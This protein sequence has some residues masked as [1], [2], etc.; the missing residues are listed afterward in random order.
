MTLSLHTLEKSKGTKKTK[1]RLGRGYGSGKGGHTVGRGM[2]G[3]KSRAGSSGHKRR[4]M[5]RLM[6]STPKLRGFNSP[7][8]KPQTVNVSQIDASYI[9][10]E[11]V[12]PKTLASKGLVRYPNKPVKILANGEIAK[13]VTVKSC[14]VSKTAAEKIIAAGGKI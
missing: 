2:K 5:R 13:A 7:N 12:T 3:Q 14:S 1:K 9:A 6:L 10:K 4:G 11:V 8:E